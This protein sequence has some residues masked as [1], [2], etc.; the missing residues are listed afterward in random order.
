VKSSCADTATSL[1]FPSNH[2]PEGSSK[3]GMSAA[4]HAAPSRTF[5]LAE[6]AS[7]DAAAATHSEASGVRRLL[8]KVSLSS[9]KNARPSFSFSIGRNNTD[10]G[11][12]RP[13]IPTMM[14][15]SG[16]IY[17]TPLPRLP[18]IVLSIVRFCLYS[19][20]WSCHR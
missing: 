11:A 2:H 16:E 20:Q 15:P 3:Q 14:K 8:G 10:P 19:F 4:R 17:S 18:M 7:D 9:F 6:A 13:P 5:G 1:I 12:D